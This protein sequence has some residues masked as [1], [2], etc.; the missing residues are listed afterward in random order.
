MLVPP[1]LICIFNANLHF[2]VLEIFLC[3]KIEESIP[4]FIWK[5]KGQ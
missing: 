1:K 3:A 4:E 2:K 5:L